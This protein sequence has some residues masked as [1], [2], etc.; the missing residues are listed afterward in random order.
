MRVPD[1]WRVNRRYAANSACPRCG[2]MLVRLDRP[3]SAT[4]RERVA[5]DDVEVTA[6]S[7]DGFKAERRTVGWRHTATLRCPRCDRL[8]SP[9]QARRRDFRDSELP[10]DWLVPDRGVE[11]TADV[12][13]GLARS[14]GTGRRG[15][16][17]PDPE[18]GELDLGEA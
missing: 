5:A 1:G 4:S 10:A 3:V 13:R 8:Y 9:A 16:A 18:Q 12:L 2:S 11:A 14:L 17:P 15:F 6:A 7:G